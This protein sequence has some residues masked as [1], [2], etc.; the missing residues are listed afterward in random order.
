[1]TD[2]KYA[3]LPGIDRGQPD[4]Y[5]TSDLPEDDQQ[6]AKHTTDEPSSE[7]VE[8]LEVTPS[9]AFQQFKGK[10]LET[11]SADFSD[12]IGRPQQTG[13]HIP[14]SEYEILGEGD[15]VKETPD[16]RF[17]RLQHEI[18]ELADDI[19][20]IKESSSGEGGGVTGQ[21]STSAI[22]LVRQ[23]EYLQH[24]LTD[25]HLDQ[26][27][28]GAGVS[29]ADPQGALQKRL[30]TELD[31]FKAATTK[32]LADKSKASPAGAAPA[33]ADS[34]H[35]NYQ[36]FYRPEQAKFGNTARV[37]ELEQRLERLE[38]LLG[39]SPEKTTALNADLATKSL[40]MAI[41]TLAARTKLLDPSHLDQVE[42]RLGVVQQRLTQVAEKKDAVEQQTGKSDKISELYDLVKK[43]QPIV[44][45][46]PHIADRLTALQ[47]LHE[48]ALEFSQ[49]L[50]QLET[51][52]AEI[53]SH[54]TLD[55]D[56]IKQVQ[57]SFSE[58]MA[59]IMATCEA[60]GKRIDA[61]NKQP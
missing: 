12:R 7:S 31:G 41:S 8:R 56:V 32:P 53:S 58:N 18:R 3:N 49:A 1:M 44:T 42:S 61:L 35:V 14:R 15:A 2:Y 9:E 47:E 13:Y 55:S 11:G 30:I 4:V 17:Q 33:V 43:W 23:L 37:A 5:E 27:L 54:L 50:T 16:Q 10:K 48:Q 24:Q 60:F 26:Q 20:L 57:S 59:T 45:S 39:N 46:L 22:A 25:L 28:E 19:N 51:A 52:Q 36:M 38:A 29:L 6:L 34:D 21:S 40:L